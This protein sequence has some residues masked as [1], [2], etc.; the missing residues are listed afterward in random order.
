MEYSAVFLYLSNNFQI[1]LTVIEHGRRCAERRTENTA[2]EEYGLPESD[3]SSRY[4]KSQHCAGRYRGWSPD[5][6][7]EK[8]AQKIATPTNSISS[9]ILYSHLSGSWQST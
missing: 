8:S 4:E 7:H 1:N 3:E 5:S 9:T 6:E 2:V